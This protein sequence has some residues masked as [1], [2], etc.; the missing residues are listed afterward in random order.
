MLT[1]SSLLKEWKRKE[2]KRNSE[3]I[4]EEGDENDD[5]KQKKWLWI[6]KAK[7]ESRKWEI[8]ENEIGKGFGNWLLK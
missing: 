7:Q 5:V 2:K 3:V 6:G 1:N 8:K 4:G